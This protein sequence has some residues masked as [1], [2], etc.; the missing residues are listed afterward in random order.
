MSSKVC[1]KIIE[2]FKEIFKK[3]SFFCFGITAIYIFCFWSTH[4][5]YLK[6]GVEFVSLQEAKEEEEL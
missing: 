5:K 1:L 6:F 4:G 2:W 3:K